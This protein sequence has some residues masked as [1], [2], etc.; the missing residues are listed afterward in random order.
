VWQEE[1]EKM[2]VSLREK[3]TEEEKP[4]EEEVCTSSTPLDRC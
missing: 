4:F 3:Q 1:E 2:R